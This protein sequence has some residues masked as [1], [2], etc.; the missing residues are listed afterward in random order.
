METFETNMKSC[1]INSLDLWGLKQAKHKWWLLGAE[2][3]KP[4]K[5]MNVLDIG[6]P[7]EAQGPL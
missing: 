2:Q 7:Q 3:P 6:G 4:A 5:E 1:V